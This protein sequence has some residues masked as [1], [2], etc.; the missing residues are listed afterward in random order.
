MKWKGSIFGDWVTEWPQVSD[1]V[2]DRTKS[3]DAAASKEIKVTIEPGLSHRH[4]SL[5]PIISN[6]RIEIHQIFLGVG[7]CREV[8][9][10]QWFLLYKQCPGSPVPGVRRESVA[11]LVSG[12]LGLAVL[13]SSN[14]SHHLYMGW[15]QLSLHSYQEVVMNG[16]LQWMDHL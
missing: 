3:R 2:T 10:C 1:W 4:G 6:E 15:W 11:I 12:G 7:R 13:A 9:Y 16:S 8:Q 14:C 5:L